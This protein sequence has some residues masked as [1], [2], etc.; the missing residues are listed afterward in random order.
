MT[1]SHRERLQAVLRGEAPDRIPV[2][3]WRHFPVDD[4]Q[5]ELLAGAVL[6]FQ[7]EYDFD[8][9]KGDPG[10]ELLGA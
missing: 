1:V 9:I 6:A 4:Q 5:P 10:L 3:L 8:L 7:R 2:A